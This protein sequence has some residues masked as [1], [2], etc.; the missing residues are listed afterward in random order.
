MLGVSAIQPLITS[1]TDVSKTTIKRSSSQERWRRI[2]VSSAKQSERA[3]VPTVESPVSIER[4]LSQKSSGR[5]LMLVEPD[6]Q[7]CYKRLDTQSTEIIPSQAIVTIGPE[8]GWSNREL[9]TA[10]EEA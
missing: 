7:S 10:R 8:D 3:V 6:A 9:A 2:A 1:Y 5:R 4:H